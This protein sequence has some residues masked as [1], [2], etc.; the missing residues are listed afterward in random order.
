MVKALEKPRLLPVL[1]PLTELDNSETAKRNIDHWSEEIAANKKFN[2]ELFER[3]L[4]RMKLCSYLNGALGRSVNSH[5]SWCPHR[6]WDAY[7]QD[8]GW[9]PL[10][11]INDVER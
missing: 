11:Q 6:D 9:P 4:K 3:G 7:W 8:Q 2:D 5:F 10:P 1:P